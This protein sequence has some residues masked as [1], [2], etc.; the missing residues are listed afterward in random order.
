MNRALVLSIC[1]CNMPHVLTHFSNGKWT[2]SHCYSLC[3]QLTVWWITARYDLWPLKCMECIVE[4]GEKWGDVQLVWRWCH[5]RAVGF[6]THRGACERGFNTSVQSIRPLVIDSVVC[7][8]YVNKCG[9][10]VLL[11]NE[12]VFAHIH[13]SCV[14]THVFSS[15]QNDH[16]NEMTP[17]CHQWEFL[18]FLW[19][20]LFD[21]GAIQFK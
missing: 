10:G 7:N 13:T 18:D 3:G 15:C 6:K 14:S 12:A 11:F 16:I 4:T 20:Q 8:V 1:L 17:Q 21:L 2:L 9:V 5:T 19:G